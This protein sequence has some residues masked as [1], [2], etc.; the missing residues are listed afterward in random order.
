MSQVHEVVVYIHGVMGHAT[1]KAWDPATNTMDAF[2]LRHER[3]YR[4]FHDRLV[5][6]LAHLDKVQDAIP[7]VDVEWG[8][9]TTTDGHKGHEL[10]THAQAWLGDRVMEKVERQRDLGSLRPMVNTALGGQGGARRLVMY[11]IADAFYYTSQD[12]KADVRNAVAKQIKAR[13]RDVGGPQWKNKRFSLTLVGHSAGSL[14]AFD[15][16]Y[17]IFG[18][19]NAAVDDRFPDIAEL[20]KM[21]HGSADERR[22]RV[23][24][25]VT[26]GSPI[27]PF[28]IRSNAVVELLARDEQMDPKD[29]GLTDRQDFPGELKLKTPR[30][31]WLN[32]WD[33][34]DLI[35][36][37]VEPLMNNPAVG[38]KIVKDVHPDVSDSLGKAHEDFWKDD[39]VTDIIA[40]YW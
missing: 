38:G 25:L 31:R 37:P 15:L 32:F 11:G 17:Y 27:T 34:D 29:Y 19:K 28:A 33:R 8:W 10:L 5:D 22:L 9:A 1:T 12:G 30:P 6:E 23:R 16:L 21:A 36:Y 13:L 2:R 39:K 3:Q 26:M 18:A 20:H 35:S 40:R 24:Q 14:V 7:R 4:E